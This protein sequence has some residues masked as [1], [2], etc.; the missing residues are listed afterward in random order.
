MDNQPFTTEILSP[1]DANIATCATALQQGQVVAFGTETVYGLGADIFNESAV[2]NIYNIKGRPSDNPLIVH[3]HSLEQIKSLSK[4]NPHVDKLHSAFMPGPLTIVLDKQDNVP[5]YVT[6]GQPTVAIRIPKSSTALK[7]L[8]AVNLPIC[9]PSAN[10]SGRPSPTNARDVLHD[11]HGKIQYILDSNSECEIGIESTILDL[12]KPV[13][14]ILRH[15]A[16]SQA[17]LSQVLGLQVASI[18]EHD[19]S[20]QAS[21][22]LKYRHYAPSVP[23]FFIEYDSETFA[24]ELCQALKFANGLEANPNSARIP[25]SNGVAF[26]Q[27]GLLWPENKFVLL[28]MMQDDPMLASFFANNVK[29]EVVG[30]TSSEDYARNLYQILRIQE[31][32]CTAI[33][34]LGMPPE[35]IGAGL[36]NRLRKAAGKA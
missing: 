1:T 15:G 31:T 17:Q 14:T 5:D 7:L 11:L 10:T 2:R 18:D 25:N 27:V 35:G 28:K 19:T 32:F 16:V 33:I 4:P 12:T 26:K 8:Q 34:A 30:M 9:A 22:G 6:A 24:Q 3:V 21:P 23:M 29:Y 20:G 13:P 36:N